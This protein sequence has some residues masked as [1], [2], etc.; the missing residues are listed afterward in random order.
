MLSRSELIRDRLLVEFSQQNSIRTLT[1]GLSTYDFVR[2]ASKTSGLSVRLPEMPAIIL[3]VDVDDVLHNPNRLNIRGLA[4]KKSNRINSHLYG[5]CVR[6][7]IL[8]SFCIWFVFVYPTSSC[9]HF[10][11]VVFSNYLCSRQPQLDWAP[12]LLSLFGS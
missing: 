3:S 1:T 4:R 11:L 7:I 5:N 6:E 9:L 12:N 10:P 8:M 2:M